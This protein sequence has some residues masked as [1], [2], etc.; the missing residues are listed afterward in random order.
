MEFDER[1]Y[2][3]L[4]SDAALFL[5]EIHWMILKSAYVMEG[6]RWSQT[7]QKFGKTFESTEFGEEVGMDEIHWWIF[8]KETNVDELTTRTEATLK[9]VQT[10]QIEAIKLKRKESATYAEL[11][12]A[13]R[14]FADDNSKEIEVLHE[15]V[16]WLA[17]R[18]PM[19]P[20]ILFT[21]RIW[22]STRMADREMELGDA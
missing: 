22:G 5:G 3:V 16:R 4:Y 21:Y 14:G 8:K 13:L 19:A 15:Y 7:G 18:D 12:V 1:L 10:L 2:D 11:L 20:R 17:Q 9:S 6:K